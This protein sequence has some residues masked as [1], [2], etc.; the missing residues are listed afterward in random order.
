[1]GFLFG[2][3]NRFKK[4]K[5][6][7]IFLYT[8]Q[9]VLLVPFN[10]V[11][12]I[13]GDILPGRKFSFQS[14]DSPFDSIS[15]LGTFFWL[16]DT[17]IIS[18]YYIRQFVS[19]HISDVKKSNYPKIYYS[20]ISSAN[21]DNA[22]KWTINCDFHE[23]RVTRHLSMTDSAFFSLEKHGKKSEIVNSCDFC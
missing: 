20:A 10:N 16:P 13:Y 17:S 14:R 8:H 2:F 7:K 21:V 23:L 4:Y 6:Y 9:L 1:M 22:R 18:V 5:T 3:Q 15:K 11:W 12:W 19:K